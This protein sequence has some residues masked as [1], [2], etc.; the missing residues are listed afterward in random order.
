MDSTMRGI[1]W[2]SV[3]YGVAL[4]L[5][6]TWAHAQIVPTDET[7]YCYGNDC[8]TRA[9][10]I[11]RM[12][13]ANPNYADFL[14]QK[15]PAFF[16]RTDGLQLLELHF[17]VED[18]P[19]ASTNTA[20]YTPS[21]TSSPAPQF[22]AP[23][24]DPVRPNACADQGQM[25]QAIVA[26]EHAAH[27]GTVQHW[28][29]KHYFTPFSESA[30]H[31]GVQ[32]SLRYNHDNNPA[33]QTTLHIRF[34]NA[35]GSPTG[36]NDYLLNKFA[37]YQ[38]PA[39]F[40]ARTGPHATYNPASSSPVKLDEV[41]TAAV[42]LKI[43][44]RK[45]AMCPTTPN[46]PS[47][48]GGAPCFPTTGDKARFET[49]FEFAGRPFLRA[50]HSLQQTGQRPELAPGWTHTYSERIVGSPYNTRLARITDSGYFETYKRIG[51]TPRFVSP[52][53][54]K[55]V[56]DLV[57][58][59][60]K[61]VFKLSDG[62]DA[63]RYFSD[64]GRLLRI[65]DLGTGGKLT[66]GYDGERLLTVADATGLKLQ[67][68]YSGFRLS[69]VQLPDGNTVQYAYDSDRNLQSV[70]Y[71]DGSIRT[72]HYN[73]AGYS[74]ANDPNALTGISDNG[75]RYLT[76]AYD[77][78]GRARLSQAHTAGGIV[79]KTEL[80]YTGDT[81]VTVTGHHGETRQYAL[82]SSSGFRRVTGLTASDGSVGNTFDGALVFESRDKRNMITRHEYTADKAYSNARYDAYG[83]TVERRTV[84][85]R[86]A[87]YRVTSVQIQAKSGANHVTKQ[88][89]S[90]TY[91]SRGQV[92]TSTT[93]D[94]ATSQS[95]TVTTTYCE[96]ADVTAGTCPFVGYIQSV[97]GPRTD[98]VDTIAY[99]YRM[100][101]HPDCATAPS[102]C[103]YRR[104]QVWKT[105]NAL[106]Q[107]F[108]IAAYNMYGKPL[109]T[110]DPDG[111]VTDFDYDA[112]GRLTAR[113]TRGANNAVETD[114]RITR[115]EYWPV[116]MV[117]KVTQP[118]GAFT[119]YT[120]DGAHRLT[121]IA[122]GEGNSIAYTLN[123]A[124]DRIAEQT[125]DDQGL[126]LRTLARTYNSL[127][128]LQAQT[129]A[130][131]RNTTFAYDAAGN[132][133][134]TTDALLHVTDNNVDPLN[135]L[136]RTL[137]DVN[138][139][140]AE[141]K[142][143][144]DVLDNLTQ[145]NDPKGLDTNY[146][147]NGFGDLTQLQS[148]DTGTVTYTYDSAG[149][150]ASQAD[151]RGVTT[152]YGY[153]ALN[154]LTSIAYPTAAL[155]TGYVYDT[156]QAVCQ[157]G[158]GFGVGRLTKIVDGSGSTSYCYDRFGNLVRKVQVT[159]GQTFTLRY[160]FNVAGQMT[161]MVYPDGALVDY[162]HDALGRV[163]EVG[164]TPA[165]GTRQVVLAD[166]TYYPFGPVAE[167]VYGNG[168]VMKRSL[169]RNYQPG[170]V[171][172][173]GPGGL[174]LGYEFDEVGNLRTLRTAA[175]AEPP[176]R[177]FGY[178]GLNRLVETK[179]GTT[180]AVLEA[181]AYDPTGNRTSATVSGATTAYGYG[182]GSHRLNSV[183]A[184]ARS[185]DNAG[186]TTQIGGTAK[187]FAYND[188][189]RMSQYLES[190]IVKRNYAYNGRG[191]QVRTW[192]AANDDRYSLYD[193]GGQW[194]GEYDASG[195]PVQQIVWLGSLPVG[196]L[197]GSGAAQKLHYIEADALGT[198]RVVVDPTRG[199]GGTAVWR[200]ALTGEAFGNTAPDHD[201]DG[202]SVAFVFD[203]RFPGQ[204]YD[205]VSGFNQNGFR[206]YEPGTGRYP[207]SDPIGLNG[208]I[209]TYGYVGGRPLTSIDPEGLAAFTV[210]LAPA[211][212]AVI[213]SPHPVVVAGAVGA[214]IGMGF[215]YAWERVAGQAFGSS[216]YDWMNPGEV[217]SPAFASENIN[218]QGQSGINS[219]P[220]G[221]QDPCKGLRDQLRDHE[222]K[223]R[224]YIANPL[225]MDN[226]GFLA[227]ALAK[228]DMNL[229]NKIY[230]SR[231]ASLQWQIENFRKQLQACESKYGI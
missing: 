134:T 53:D 161:G 153:D 47:E 187:A 145:V 148:P 26:A 120:Y 3:A 221:P 14:V 57:V 144:Y 21:F 102:T 164:A 109:T 179:D 158:E 50:Y 219:C 46:V 61:Y 163:S 190:G 171:E 18:Q 211:P 87:N 218:S 174:S 155:N 136:S 168:R 183:G 85:A 215:N 52:E 169:N 186:N 137:Q 177:A 156:T 141:T 64:T 172:V 196:V 88:Q 27:G 36:G 104:G 19:A 188:L 121:G 212:G 133:D 176:L 83:T 197:T 160:L 67:L 139:I 170:F 66:F 147:Y 208:D 125:R 231:I 131:G 214:G 41:C 69:A 182:S 40:V 95:R 220:P 1:R 230:A 37:S 112:R 100:A 173:I 77:T 166:A 78:K 49:D 167:W 154:R 99:T 59:G 222:R 2:F 35:S 185:Y 113:K 206:D 76:F 157:S 32:G 116:G 38:C 201:P 108:E 216:L 28:V 30:T 199:V 210:P 198:P 110:I 94:P 55:K 8:G 75:Q 101:D 68:V 223:L 84:T 127:G 162:V 195:A 103:P 194:L 42:D 33:L 226:K 4:F 124:G 17:G 128:Q 178:D 20:V 114:D 34:F 135:R 175:Q 150:R 123:A 203:M 107:V 15:E 132:P 29:D 207:Q 90:F 70:Q 200:W 31:G 39:G 140:A 129:D 165:G 7:E 122:D 202:D 80:A 43:T 60:G 51:S 217:Y 16:E 12:K 159:N 93:T 73:E 119:S 81:Q 82:S 22:C 74:D 62:G 72:Y 45:R 89:R 23:S 130:Y 9:Y 224:E 6:A 193:E 126:L 44:T 142:F 86:D 189:N 106:G 151:A 92:L 71:A 91:N 11:G 79:Q 58:E 209:S 24:G 118:D 97:N 10:A 105:T 227:A 184:T 111:V 228:D 65:E 5:F 225:G 229:Y 180:A 204:R 138:G 115:L 146:T 213:P 149:N 56:V 48:E 192:L 96:Q 181:Y 152:T 63:V 13:A 143:S 205:A 98:V 54:A 191:E 117:K 25:V